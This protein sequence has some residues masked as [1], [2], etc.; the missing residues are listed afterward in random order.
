MV[1]VF[2][3]DKHIYIADMII[4]LYTCYDMLCV[5]MYMCVYVYVCVEPA[6][7]FSVQSYVILRSHH[8]SSHTNLICSRKYPI[9]TRLNALD[10]FMLRL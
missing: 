8:L 10:L 7:I 1:I 4:Y 5:H 6:T 3:S 9:R 2:F